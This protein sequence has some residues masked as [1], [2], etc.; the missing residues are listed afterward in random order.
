MTLTVDQAHVL[1][2]ESQIQSYFEGFNAGNFE[3]VSDLFAVEGVLQ[4]PFESA[5]VGR[6]DILAY[7][8]Q[9]AAGMQAN[10]QEMSCEALADG[11]RQ[12]VVKGRVK[13]IVFTVNV[14]WTFL[15]NQTQQLDRVEVKLLASMQ[16]LVKFR[17]SMA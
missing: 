13:A 14:A 9:E 10:P 1:Q 4:A 8:Q 6:P 12:V 17:P 15:I 16:E 5:I 7:L 11:R 3:A 2:A